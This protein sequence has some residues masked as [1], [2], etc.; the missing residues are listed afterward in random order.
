MGPGGLCCP[1]IREEMVAVRGQEMGL[2]GVE[3]HPPS[4][5]YSYGS[6]FSLQMTLVD[7]DSKFIL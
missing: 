1:P 2:E 3:C 5:G 7:G 4:Q 6:F